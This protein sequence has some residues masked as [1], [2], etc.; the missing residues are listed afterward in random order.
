LVSAPD[1]LAALA[2]PQKKW[3]NLSMLRLLLLRHA[4]AAPHDP[5]HDHARPL[6]ERGRSDAKR[7]GKYIAKQK[8]GVTASIHS[9][10][11]RAKE[12]LAIAVAE[13]PKG[14]PILIEPRLYEAPTSGFLA[15]LKDLPEDAKVVLLVGHNPSIAEAAH[16][17]VDG[18]DEE[19]LARMEAKFPTSGLAVID[20]D[21]ARWAKIGP[22]A[23]RLVDFATPASLAEDS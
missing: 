15:A 11:R 21:V 1:G 22:G 9:G 5:A 6:I 4:K 16:R 12:T 7:L 18:G 14:L 8:Y 13:L 23:G 20:F 3:H 17:L 10:A 19:A 2:P